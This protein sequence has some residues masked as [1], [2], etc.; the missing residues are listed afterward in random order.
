MNTLFVF[1]AAGLVGFKYREVRSK[2]DVKKEPETA[3]PVIIESHEALPEA[4]GATLQDLWD[5]QESISALGM[6]PKV[7][8]TARLPPHITGTNPLQSRPSS[9]VAPIVNNPVRTRNIPGLNSGREEYEEQYFPQDTRSTGYSVVQKPWMRAL[10]NSYNVPRTEKESDFPTV[11]DREDIHKNTIPA[12]IREFE[13]LQTKTT[14]PRSQE[15]QFESPVECIK[16]QNE[17]GGGLRGQRQHH[18][19]HKFLL[20]DQP[21]LDM[22][23][24]IKGNFSG[25]KKSGFVSDMDNEKAELVISHTG[26]PVSASFKVGIPEESFDLMGSNAESWTLDEHT[27]PAGSR[28]PVEM[29]A[30][31]PSF[32]V[33]HDDTI[34]A[35]RVTDQANLSR[36]SRPKPIS[37]DQDTSSFKDST[38]ETQTVLGAPG[39]RTLKNVSKSLVKDKAKDEVLARN[40][41]DI[42]FRSSAAS[43][44]PSAPAS[45]QFHTHSDDRFA[46]QDTSGRVRGSSLLTKSVVIDK[47][48]LLNDMKDDINIKEFTSKNFVAPQNQS[49]HKHLRTAPTASVT[50]SQDLSLK[51]KKLPAEIDLRRGRIA[52][53]NPGKNIPLVGVATTEERHLGTLLNNRMASRSA[54]KLL[55]NPY[56]RPGAK[57]LQSI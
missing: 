27:L 19:Y 50:A 46:E 14:V 31:L 7:N 20:N 47:S 38:V 22:H 10:E 34:D 4:V 33:A 40:A 17:G 16:T 3:E 48:L 8:T 55:S 35:Y 13:R 42:D 28:A 21:T 44:G 57:R 23:E 51:E 12:R 36:S 5:K 18:R 24:G 45:K 2:K 37:V 43:A 54:L 39:G 32:K 15:K 49:L 30:V 29:S 56:A 53:A 26:V 11:D 1:L 25:A 41:S 52:V 6:Q 9:F